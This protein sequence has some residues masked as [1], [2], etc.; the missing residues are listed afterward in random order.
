LKL[1]SVIQINE[2]SETKTSPIHP[3]KDSLVEKSRGWATTGDDIF[4]R[5]S[6]ERAYTMI[7]STTSRYSLETS[8]S[9]ACKAL[10]VV[11]PA[12]LK[13]KARQI[14]MDIFQGSVGELAIASEGN[15]EMYEN[16]YNRA[17]IYTKRITEA[18]E[19]AKAQAEPLEAILSIPSVSD[20]PIV[21][22]TDLSDALQFVGAERLACIANTGGLRHLVVF[23]SSITPSSD[24]LAFNDA[25]FQIPPCAKLLK[26]F[27]P[28]YLH[29][30]AEQIATSAGVPIA[31][32]TG[33]LVPYIG[34]RVIKTPMSYTQM[35]H[36]SRTCNGSDTSHKCGDLEPAVF[37][38]AH[39]EAHYHTAVELK[40]VLKRVSERTRVSHG[41]MYPSTKATMAMIMIDDKQVHITAALS[42]KVASVVGCMHRQ[43]EARKIAEKT[44]IPLD[45]KV[46]IERIARKVSELDEDAPSLVETRRLLDEKFKECSGG[47]YCPAKLSVGV[48]DGMGPYDTHAIIVADPKTRSTIHSVLSAARIPHVTVSSSDTLGDREK[49]VTEAFESSKTPTLEYYM[50][51]QEHERQ[52]RAEAA[53]ERR[54][55]R[56][57]TRAFQ[58]DAEMGKFAKV[59]DGNCPSGTSRMSHDIA[60]SVVGRQVPAGGDAKESARAARRKSPFA[61]QSSGVDQLVQEELSRIAN[62]RRMQS[63]RE[64]APIAVVSNVTVHVAP[65]HISHVHVVDGSDE[66]HN[67]VSR[68][69]GTSDVDPRFEVRHYVA[70]AQSFTA[71]E[72]Y[73]DDPPR[74]IEGEAAAAKVEAA[75][76]D[77]E[78]CDK[79]DGVD[80]ES[81]YEDGFEA[82]ADRMMTRQFTHRRNFHYTGYAT[83]SANCTDEKDVE[84]TIVVREVDAAGQESRLA[85]T[86]S[87]SKA[88]TRQFIRTITRKYDL[89][90]C[91]A[92]RVAIARGELPTHGRPPFVSRADDCRGDMECNRLRQ[93]DAFRAEAVARTFDR[94]VGF[95]K[96][97]IARTKPTTLQALREDMKRLP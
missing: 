57:I 4:D 13:S 42:S 28:R 79:C 89:L 31:A 35:A 41:F 16:I 94:E 82:I 32:A 34:H 95:A 50:A 56:A 66:A 62:A 68:L 53:D 78:Y 21:V 97:M 60:V 83:I 18:T 19:L 48:A 54:A 58:R 38:E 70:D 6:K 96:T 52:K 8:V 25:P 26:D 9:I 33:I 72:V 91:E 84:E 24:I 40:K 87:Y 90:P 76:K 29:E 20:R 17:N 12:Q 59:L 7:H 43:Y 15:R 88:P 44:P 27:Y 85:E 64:Y 71:A 5:K 92:A 37:Y 80:P 86:K 63:V 65:S 10:I 30:T 81:D 55:R 47:G 61:V 1:K 3:T 93:L 39:H 51:M 45:V 69:Y 46:E 2:N 77:V 14:A 22:F 11:Y 73:G 23:A 75:D 36:C 67:V 74:D 49:I